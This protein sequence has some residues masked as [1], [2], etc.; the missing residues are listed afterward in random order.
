VFSYL[1]GISF[2]KTLC[3]FIFFGGCIINQLVA[4]LLEERGK[5]KPIKTESRGFLFFQKK[6]KLSKAVDQRSTKKEGVKVKYS[7]PVKYKSKV[8]V[9]TSTPTSYP[10]GGKVVPR[11]S[12]KV[13][14]NFI[15]RKI[16][17][18][19]RSNNR[20]R[21]LPTSG[22]SYGKGQF[23]LIPNFKGEGKFGKPRLT[24]V[25]PYVSR[26]RLSISKGMQFDRGFEFDQYIRLRN[27][28]K[29]L[30]GFTAVY[31][32][33]HK[34]K[35]R[36][37]T[38]PRD[39]KMTDRYGKS[40][41]SLIPKFDR[42]NFSISGNMSYDI[43]RQLANQ[44][45]P[46]SRLESGYRGNNKVKVPIFAAIQKRIGQWER[47]SYKGRT[48]GFNKIGGKA[49]LRGRSIITSDFKGTEKMSKHKGGDPHPSIAHISGKKFTSHNWK[50]KWR[51]LNIL[52]VR[53]NP[54]KEVSEGSR[55]KVKTK[56]DKEERDIWTY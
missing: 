45:K 23:T 18:Q 38:G 5:L 55:M 15:S 13:K 14:E 9:R 32:G 3:F 29:P 11:F 42:K 53:V 20:H 44:F 30:Q 8:A 51:K 19:Q 46:N 25:S 47:S 49:Y 7:L 4:Q 26:R 43:N 1:Q 10:R 54:R 41:L 31:Q 34:I 33:D 12:S 50:D 21:P 52:W 56:Y 28:M 39:L 40:K 36:G 2:N 17:E 16:A 27:Q 22:P 35:I 48:V 6:V 24:L 37:K